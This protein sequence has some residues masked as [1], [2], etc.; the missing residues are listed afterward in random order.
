MK[1]ALARKGRLALCGALCALFSLHAAGDVVLHS[2]DE[3][4]H[5]DASA[6]KE[7]VVLKS[8]A[9]IIHKSGLRPGMFVVCSSEKPVSIGLLTQLPD[10]SKLKEGD[11]IYVEGEVNIEKG[12]ALTLHAEK[13]EFIRHEP[14][15]DGMGVKFSDYRQGK[16]NGRRVTLT[17][18]IV[19]ERINV[20]SPKGPTTFALLASGGVA[21]C[22]VPGVLAEKKFSGRQVK[23]TGCPFGRWSDDGELREV[24][25]EIASLDAVQLLERDWKTPLL[26][27]SMTFSGTILI[28]LLI[29]W[30]R[31]RRREIERK[32]VAEER[33]R[34]AAELHD[35]VE[36]HFAAARLLV[37]GALHT[38]GLPDGAA[39]LLHQA[40]ATM[41][42]AKLEVR[43]AVTDL[44]RVDSVGH[45]IVEDIEEIAAKINSNGAVRVRVRL[46]G[47]PQN[48]G[49][50][51]TNDIVAIVREAVTN[52]IKHGKAKNV[53]IVGDKGVTGNGERSRRLSVVRDSSEPSRAQAR[54]EGT[55]NGL[56]DGLRAVGEASA[57]ISGGR[58]QWSGGRCQG[59][60]K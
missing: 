60:E 31:S 24:E 36:Q 34:M 26:V 41:A 43:D 38:K 20:E 29:I 13:S 42:N 37:V 27:A 7:L 25:I 5:L 51:L 40:A 9:R 53:A 16:L 22:R 47:L 55:G 3:I 57:G 54:A 2:V 4:R 33:Q 44:R 59:S 19:P 6:W 15:G 10:A 56:R 12:G 45:T 18:I 52:A 11:V 32:A 1:R 14:I 21:I 48:L 30:A 50:S 23:V 8:H 58:G 39:S 46:A 28:V 17:G 35:T 49:A